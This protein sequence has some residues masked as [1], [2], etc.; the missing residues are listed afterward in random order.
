MADPVSGTPGNPSPA[1]QDPKPADPTPA[2]D[3]MSIK[4][5]GDKVPEKLRGKSAAEIL[6]HYQDLESEFTAKAQL[7]SD[8]E[9]WYVNTHQKGTAGNGNAQPAGEEE[10][11]FTEQQVNAMS[12]LLQKNL[13][14]IVSALDNVFLENIKSM[15]P[16][17]SDYEKRAREI[18]DSMPP[19]FKY[20]P[21]HGWGFAYNMAKSESQGIPKAKPPAPITPGG[22]IPPGAPENDLSEEEMTWAKKQG[23]TPEE[24]KKFQKPVENV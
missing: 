6:K 14:P 15:V 13:Q 18:Y 2:P 5:D 3:P 17:F 16:D 20:S 10:A 21:K 1:P 8:W 12:G 7:V 22:P 11:P 19:Q 9:K 4:F 24:Y 23:M